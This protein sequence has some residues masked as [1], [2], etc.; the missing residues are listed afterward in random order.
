MGDVRMIE[1]HKVQV[2][3]IAF[4]WDGTDAGAKEIV[5]Y[6]QAH[7]ADLWLA[8]ARHAR[9]TYEGPLFTLTVYGGE[10]RLSVD[11]RPNQSATLLLDAERGTPLGM[12]GYLI[13]PATV[14][15][16]ESRK[17]VPIALREIG[18]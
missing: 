6:L 5:G 4:T 12:L 2:D 8:E 15:L 13:G 7:P 10:S 3:A 1:E 18:S 16:S 14:V 11:L 17:E 9:S